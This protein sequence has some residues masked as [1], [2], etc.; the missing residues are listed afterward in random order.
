MH[1]FSVEAM[2]AADMGLVFSAR[3]L[4]LSAAAFMALGL[5]LGMSADA[6]DKRMRE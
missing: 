5:M 2:P 4:F 3:T 1:T 6:L